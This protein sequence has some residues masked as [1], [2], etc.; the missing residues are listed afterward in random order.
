M[1]GLPAGHGGERD[2]YRERDCS[3]GMRIAGG[4]TSTLP[5]RMAPTTTA[6]HIKDAPAVGPRGYA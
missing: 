3:A 2:D 6:V 5:E 4:R 1:A